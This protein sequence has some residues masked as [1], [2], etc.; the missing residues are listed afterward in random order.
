MTLQT[1]SAAQLADAFGDNYG[2][3]EGAE[4]GPFIPVNALWSTA[5]E[6]AILAMVTESDTPCLDM[7][8]HLVWLSRRMETAAEIGASEI[9]ALQA[10][11]HELEAQ[12]GGN[13]EPEGESAE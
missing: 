12:L 10:R 3:H 1:Y 5:K 2:P 4:R 13:H 11:V 9:R 7:G 6:I 8:M